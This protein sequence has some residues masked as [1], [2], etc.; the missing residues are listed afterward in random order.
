MADHYQTVNMWTGD[1]ITLSDKKCKMQY[2]YIGVLLR[3]LTLR[4]ACIPRYDVVVP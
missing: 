2:V 4:L 3:R 1:G